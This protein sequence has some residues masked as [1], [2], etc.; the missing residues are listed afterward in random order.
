VI[1]VGRPA[2]VQA[3]HAMYDWIAA[4]LERFGLE[5]WTT[6]NQ[7]QWAAVAGSAGIPWCPECETW[8]ATYR[9]RG[10]RWCEQCDKRVLPARPL[11]HGVTWKTGFYRGALLRIATR[12][13]AQRK[14]QQQP[15]PTRT[16]AS[17]TAGRVTALVLRTD[18]ENAAYIWQ[19]YGEPR[20]G[21]PRRDGYHAAA[22][23]RG[24]ERGADVSLTASRALR[25]G[26]E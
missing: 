19:R 6:F 24:H 11:I 14:A 21:R 4:Q 20:Q 1:V 22:Y 7:E 13:S 8:T 9:V 26:E 10:Q 5:E 16:T 2:N 23:Q 25:G 12:L 3:T 15:P 18:Q 17:A